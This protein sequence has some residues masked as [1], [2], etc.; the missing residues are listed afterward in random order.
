MDGIPKQLEPKSYIRINSEGEPQLVR[1]E[2]VIH[3]GRVDPNVVMV[4]LDEEGPHEMPRTA[5]QMML[6]AS[7]CVPLE[8]VAGRQHRRVH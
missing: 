2:P 5:F 6:M 3:D 7:E 4:Y 8:V 1:V